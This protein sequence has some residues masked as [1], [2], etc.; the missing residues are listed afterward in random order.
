MLKLKK[1]VFPLLVL[2]IVACENE[3][4]LN[5]DFEETTVVFGFLDKNADTQFVKISKTFID[6]QLSAIDVAKQSDRLFYD[7]LEVSLINNY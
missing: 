2:F 3:V 4:D 1:F 6:D 5:T 7:T